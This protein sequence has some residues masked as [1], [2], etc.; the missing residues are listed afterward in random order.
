MVSLAELISDLLLRNDAIDASVERLTGFSF[1]NGGDATISPAHRVTPA[2]DHLPASSAAS[3]VGPRSFIILGVPQV[4]ERLRFALSF[5]PPLACR[6]FPSDCG[7]CLRS[8]DQHGFTGP[9]VLPG[10]HPDA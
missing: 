9:H 10:P 8:V 3:A 4:P 7:E 1:A 2:D 5:Q 6:R